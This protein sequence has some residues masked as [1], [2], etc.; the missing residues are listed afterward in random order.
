V[1]LAVNQKQTALVAF[2]L[3]DTAVVPQSIQPANIQSATLR[4]YIVSSNVTAASP[5]TVTVHAITSNWQET[6]TGA[7]APLP[8]IDPN[9]LATI[10]VAELT[11]KTYV[12]VPLTDAVVAALQNGNVHGFALQTAGA[13]TKVT[14]ASKEGPATG[15]SAELEIVANTGVDNNGNFSATSATFD[16]PLRVSSTFIVEPRPNNNP[17]SLDS[18]I[19]IGKNSGQVNSTGQLNTFVGAAAGSLNSD[20]ISN[21]FF[22][23]NAGQQN[24][25][26]AGNSFFGTAAGFSNTTG[27][28]NTMVGSFAGFAATT[29]AENV[30]L[31]AGAGSNNS[32]GAQ[33]TFIGT[34][35]GQTSNTESKNTYIGYATGGAP[36]ITKATAI[37][38]GASV[39][40]S[41]SLILGDNCNVGIGTGSPNSTLQVVGSLSLPVRTS[42]QNTQFLTASDYVLVSTA[43]N[44]TVVLPLVSTGVTGRIYIVKNRGNSA[45]TLGSTSPNETIDGAATLSIS[46]G[47]V[48]QVISNGTVWFKIN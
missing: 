44:A 29:G 37:G 17:A 27:D 26:G 47:S 30:F 1:A 46:A 6:F 7:P 3:T 31:G 4:L 18:N 15:Y 11:P 38:Y 5:G 24:T 25:H 42:G 19:F 34:D 12:N 9:V 41:N 35:S 20:G 43:G 45:I 48:A 23:A 22:G 28:S 8:T 21:A 40:A 32:S 33:N 39:T 2:A 10:S 14:F 16:G 36:G 13:K